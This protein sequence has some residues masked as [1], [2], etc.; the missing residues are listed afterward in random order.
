MPNFD[1]SETPQIPEPLP[2][3]RRLEAPCLPLDYRA[4]AEEVDHWTSLG[5]ARLPVLYRVLRLGIWLIVAVAMC[6]AMV[7]S[8]HPHN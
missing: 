3:A 2:V 1:P 4:H 7:C 5:S 6:V 8:I